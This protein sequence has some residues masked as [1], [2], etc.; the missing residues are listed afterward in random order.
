MYSTIT[1]EKNSLILYSKMPKS[2]SA[3]KQ[4]RIPKILYES[5]RSMTSHGAEK[6]SA[7][8]CAKGAPSVLPSIHCVFAFSRWPAEVY[9]V[10]FLY[11]CLQVLPQHQ[12]YVFFIKIPIAYMFA[13]KNIVYFF[14]YVLPNPQLYLSF[15]QILIVCIFVDKKKH[16]LFFSLTTSKNPI[17]RVFIQIPILYMF[18][19]KKKLFILFF[20][21][22]RN[23]TLL[24][25]SV[26]SPELFL[27]EI[28]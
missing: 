9:S 12:L 24:K 26:V 23:P 16:C 3:M 17:V 22:F 28:L 7:Y 5:Q 4:I 8:S 25:I 21:Y 1:S 6:S 18:V 19:D 13:K 15:V 2:K 14:Y 20:Q 27:T 10:N 11:S